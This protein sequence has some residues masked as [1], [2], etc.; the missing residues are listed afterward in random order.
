MEANMI[1]GMKWGAI[2]KVV[3]LETAETST[4][5]TFKR[6]A[7]FEEY[8]IFNRTARQ[9]KEDAKEFAKFLRAQ[10]PKGKKLTLEFISHMNGQG[11]EYL[12]ARIC[13]YKKEQI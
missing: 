7:P 12:K 2:V 4:R 10:L 11:V 6:L 8:P 1:L 5:I 13:I 9:L 3:P